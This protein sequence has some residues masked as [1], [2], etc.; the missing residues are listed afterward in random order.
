MGLFYYD[1]N[2]KCLY[3]SKKTNH[4]LQYNP[5]V[6]KNSYKTKTHCITNITSSEVSRFL[7]QRVCLCH[8]G[9]KYVS[10]HIA[11]QIVVTI[12]LTHMINK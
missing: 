7:Q 3:Q 9:G 8:G 2:Y 12:V 5:K 10:L 4:N 1:A 6:T 11:D